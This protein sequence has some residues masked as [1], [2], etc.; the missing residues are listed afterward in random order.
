MPCLESTFKGS[1]PWT[2][3][4]AYAYYAC[5]VQETA[6]IQQIIAG[7]QQVAAFYFADKQHDIASRAQDRLDLI[8]NEQ[9]A[10]A[11]K[12]RAQY[13]Y[14]IECERAMLDQSC[15]MAV[16]QPDY[17]AIKARV[18]APII[19]QFSRARARLARCSTVHCAAAACDAEAKLR[20]QEASALARAL[21]AAYRVEERL[22]ETRRATRR[23][24]RLQALQHMRGHI[25]GASAALAGATQAAIQAGQI[26]PYAGWSQA[27]NLAA[28]RASGFVAQDAALTAAQAV[29]R[30]GD[31][32]PAYTL[33]ATQYPG[34]QVQLDPFDIN[35][36]GL[37]MTGDLMSG[38]GIDMSALPQ[39]T[40]ST[41]QQPANDLGFDFGDI[42]W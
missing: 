15:D 21:E 26:N 19:A 28:G 36:G 23:A 24:E 35:A 5:Q 4:S 20:A 34:A 12:L 38:T 16:P 22:Y 39:V 13:E 29:R 33:G 30:A 10:S 41:G 25:Q 27:I 32:G 40:G 42:N 3:A 9:L 14:G 11:A 18:S 31:D 7:L 8:A 6:L 2:Q 37:G 17:E 1:G